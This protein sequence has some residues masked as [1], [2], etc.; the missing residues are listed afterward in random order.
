MIGQ[1]TDSQLILFIIM[2]K[3]DVEIFEDGIH[4]LDRLWWVLMAE[5]FHSSG[6]LI[7]WSVCQY[8]SILN[9]QRCEEDLL[10]P[11]NPNRKELFKTL[12]KL[13]FKKPIT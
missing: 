4:A 2:N 12:L 13:A 10:P 8:I 1:V 11:I 6:D 5:S 7:N 9:Y 3:T